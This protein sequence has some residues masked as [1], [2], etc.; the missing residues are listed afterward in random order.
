MAADEVKV[1][2][3][4]GTETEE[5]GVVM[6][7][8]EDSPDPEKSPELWLPELSALPSKLGVATADVRVTS[9]GLPSPMEVAT[10]E[11]SGEV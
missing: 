2:D 6:T 11:G 9:E 3:W 10:A 1:V 7:S 4:G 8:P 5:V